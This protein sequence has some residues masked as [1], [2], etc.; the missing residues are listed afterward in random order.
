MYSYE[1]PLVNYD[2][3]TLEVCLHRGR[4]GDVS[5]CEIPNF[6]VCRDDWAMQLRSTR[7]H[8]EVWVNLSPWRVC[9]RVFSVQHSIPMTNRIIRPTPALALVLLYNDYYT[10]LV[11]CLLRFTKLSSMKGKYVWSTSTLSRG[12][13]SIQRRRFMIYLIQMWDLWYSVWHVMRGLILMEM[14]RWECLFYDFLSYGLVDIG[15]VSAYIPWR[16][17]M[18]VSCVEQ[19]LRVF[20]QLSDVS[21]ELSIIGLWVPRIT[22]YITVWCDLCL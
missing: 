1:P 21:I 4:F 11:L 10:R 19:L 12:H 17:I 8:W 16:E 20:G 18:R 15:V 6:C 5:I 9:A 3:M 13:C 22:V 2:D 7:R 14:S